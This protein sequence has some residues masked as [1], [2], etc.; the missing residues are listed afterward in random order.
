MKKQFLA[1]IP[2]LVLSS[3]TAQMAQA[4]PTTDLTIGGQFVPAACDISL[5][6]G[7]NFSYGDKLAA[8]MSLVVPKE[9]EMLETTLN[10]TCSGAAQVGI[11]HFDNNGASL[12]DG[13]DINVTVY[14]GE[15]VKAS[16][17]LAGLGLSKDGKKIGSYITMFK[18]G[19]HLVDGNAVDQITRQN[20]TDQ[21]GK[22]T[23]GITQPNG[24]GFGVQR[25]AS[26]AATGT[27]TPIAFTNY[28]GTLGVRAGIGINQG[29]TFDD[30][31]NL[32]GNSTLEL[33]YL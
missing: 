13:D 4:A 29:L 26:F 19:S 5:G 17:T 32:Q 9:L 1:A 16:S 6:N 23:S 22:A 33:I 18:P 3:L 24:S 12:V 10:I 8:D 20:T 21:W 14:D 7:G 27:L 30:V 15:A 11:T 28:T 31:V 25:V 2:F